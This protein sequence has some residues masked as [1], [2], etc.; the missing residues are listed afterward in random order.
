MRLAIPLLIQEGGCAIKKKMRSLRGGADGAPRP[1]TPSAPFKEA[2]RLL[3]DVA[4]TPP[5]SGEEWRTRFVRT[6]YDRPYFLDS[7]KI[8][9]LIERPY[10]GSSTRVVCVRQ[11]LH[12]PT[13]RCHR[14]SAHCHLMVFRYLN[15]C[16]IPPFF[17]AVNLQRESIKENYWLRGVKAWPRFP[18]LV[19]PA[20]KKYTFSG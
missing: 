6:L 7:R 20:S 19:R 10:K 4:S 14:E 8:R 5:M 11:N 3:L 2:S 1:T 12:A 13:Y 9:T 18:S 17:V 15:E 16:R